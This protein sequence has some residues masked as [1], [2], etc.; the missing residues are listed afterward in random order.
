[1]SGA[2]DNRR[3]PCSVTELR[4]L[5]G[6]DHGQGQTI[7][8]AFRVSMQFTVPS[9]RRSGLPEESDWITRMTES[10][11]DGRIHGAGTQEA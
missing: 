1:L 6:R 3:L 4:G 5:G 11:V 7:I 10:R 9:T 8:E 2:D